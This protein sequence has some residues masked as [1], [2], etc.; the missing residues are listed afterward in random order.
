MFTPDKIVMIERTVD[1]IRMIDECSDDSNS[2][3]LTIEPENKQYKYRITINNYY[4]GRTLSHT[5]TSIQNCLDS[6]RE[7]LVKRIEDVYTDLSRKLAIIQEARSKI[8]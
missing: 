6:L 7:S 4:G 2:I 1:L 8:S 5:D 3:E